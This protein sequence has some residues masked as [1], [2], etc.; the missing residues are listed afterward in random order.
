MKQLQVSNL[1]TII[2]ISCSVLISN[3]GYA[4]N[5]QREF[6]I[7]SPQDVEDV[8]LR[9]SEL[10]YEDD[11]YWTEWNFGKSQVLDVG[12]ASSVWNQYFAV[13]LIR[14]DLTGLACGTVSDATLRLYKPMNVTQLTSEV[15]V[16]VFRITNQNKDWKE[17]SKES[18][19]PE[20][21]ATWH[22]LSPGRPWAGSNSGCSFPGV[23]FDITPLDT[24]IAIREKGKW[25]EFS[26]PA[27]LVQSWLE[28]PSEN[29][30]LLIKAAV[31]R[32]GQH[33]LFY[34]SEHA[35][36]KGP[37]LIING[38]NSV[39][40]HPD[41]TD[42]A[43]NPRYE[44]PPKGTAFEKYLSEDNSRYKKWT[45]DPELNLTGDQRIY[46]YYWD[47]VVDGEIIMPY[48]YYP[49]SRSILKLDSLIQNKDVKGL[50]EWHKARLRYAHVWEYNKEQRWYETGDVIE[51]LSPYQAALIWLRKNKDVSG[52]NGILAKYHIGRP[53]LTRSDIDKRVKRE[54]EEINDNLD[55]TPSRRK[56]IE[57][58]IE[59]Q[60]R[61]RNHYFNLCNA[62]AQDVFALLD[63][64]KNGVEM[65]DALGRFMIYHDKYLYHDSQY[66]M[67]RWPVL[68]D[69]SDIIKYTLYWKKQK[70]GE[71]APD[72]MQRRW[73]DIIK[74]WPETWP[75]PVSDVSHVIG[76]E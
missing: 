70:Y 23:D 60:E 58:F 42:K 2:C 72:R 62:A 63:Q 19:P 35:S 22:E 71:Y 44:L 20:S 1:L 6:I 65:I 27:A 41:N 5:T 74:Y 8:L 32:L 36:R 55:L 28:N 38:T 4:Q 76:R 67:V 37:Q 66:Q 24:K 56:V 7:S 57:P 50:K 16:S 31:T 45:V 15:P 51:I 21:G 13:S 11:L 18:L 14:F 47:I 75:L 10:T 73:D 12:Y 46:P 9:Q 68:M 3:Y 52:I 30:G 29:A 69:N 48:S 59:R 25:L 39:A 33:V 64:K 26:I 53:N 34:S 40:R 43:F 61:T 17:G 49:F 54:L